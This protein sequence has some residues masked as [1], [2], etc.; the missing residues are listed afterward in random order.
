MTRPRDKQKGKDYFELLTGVYC[1]FAVCTTDGIV[2]GCVDVPGKAGFLRSHRDMK[3][4]ILTACGM[5]YA[6]V[7]A[8]SLP[9]LETMRAAFLGEIDLG[10]A[11]PEHLTETELQDE[12][13]QELVSFAQTHSQPAPLAEARTTLQSKLEF[14]RNGRALG[15]NPLITQSGL[16]DDSPAPGFKATAAWEDSF[17]QTYPVIVDAFSRKSSAFSSARTFTSEL[18]R[19]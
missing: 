8:T 5:A 12:F 17:L 16:I 1:S 18:M 13:T 3:E 19:R 6:V 7:W 2:I 15:V 10:A 14:A 11:E 4:S 9:G